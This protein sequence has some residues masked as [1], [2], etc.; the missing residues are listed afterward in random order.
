MDRLRAQPITLR[1]RMAC[2]TSKD[3]HAGRYSINLGEPITFVASEDE[4]AT[5]SNVR[6]PDAITSTTLASWDVREDRCV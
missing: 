5:L 6:T 1:R 4:V 3:G 2:R